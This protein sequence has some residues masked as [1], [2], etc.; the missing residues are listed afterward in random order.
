MIKMQLVEGASGGV[1]MDIEPPIT[2]EQEELIRQEPLFYDI[3]DEALVFKERAPESGQSFSEVD[4]SRIDE[5]AK[6]KG[7][8]FNPQNFAREVWDV[9][10]KNG[11]AVTL[12]AGIKPLEQRGYTFLGTVHEAPEAAPGND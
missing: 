1:L 12:D 3:P 7:L 9:L 5:A 6:A 8:I 10:K 2:P 4:C 11:Y